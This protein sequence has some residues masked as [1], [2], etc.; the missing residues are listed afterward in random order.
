MYILDTFVFIAHT[1]VGYICVLHSVPLIYM[2]IFMPIPYC[3]DYYSWQYNLKSG[4][5][6]T[7]ASFFLKIALSIFVFCRS[8]QI[9]RFVCFYEKNA[10]GILTGIA[11][12]LKIALDNM[13][14]LTTLIL[15]M[16]KHGRPL[17]LCFFS[18]F[19]IN[20]NGFL[21]TSFAFLNLFLGFYCFWC[22]CK[23]FS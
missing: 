3:L 19:F 10:T 15:S 6:V 17:P 18:I 14:I 7:P 8:T 2:S 4:N 21:C 22:N 11:R 9:L 1:R 12:N 23:L 20:V 16:Y 13:D 5:V